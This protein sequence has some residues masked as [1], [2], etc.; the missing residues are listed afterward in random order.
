MLSLN[1]ILFNREDNTIGDM[2]FFVYVLTV[3]LQFLY[4]GF[5]Q[6]WY[7]NPNPTIHVN[8]LEPSTIFF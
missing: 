6:V 8:E 3:T 4:Q 7:Q 1:L 5:Q 2:S